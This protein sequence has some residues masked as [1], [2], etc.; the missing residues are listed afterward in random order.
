[1]HW[2]PA[3]GRAADFSWLEPGFL[4]E[5][6]LHLVDTWARAFEQHAI[7][8]PATATSPAIMRIYAADPGAALSL[9]LPH[10]RL[11]WVGFGPTPAE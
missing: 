7:W 5:A 2:R 3:R 11:E 1:V 4:V 10:V 8:L 9:H 6:E